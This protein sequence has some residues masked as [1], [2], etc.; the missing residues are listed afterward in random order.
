LTIAIRQGSTLPIDI[1]GGGTRDG[2]FYFGSKGDAN[3]FY[4]ERLQVYDRR[5]LP[6][7]KC[8]TA[9]ERLTQAARSTYFCPHCQRGPGGRGKIS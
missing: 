7:V 8:G 4:A 9:I 3:G 2:L 5:G 6:C 1:A